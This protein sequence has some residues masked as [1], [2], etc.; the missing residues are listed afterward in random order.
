MHTSRHVF[1]GIPKVCQTFIWRLHR[2]NIIVWFHTTFRSTGFCAHGRRTWRDYSVWDRC[3]YPNRGLGAGRSTDICKDNSPIPAIFIVR[4]VTV[5]EMIDLTWDNSSCRV[6]GSEVPGMETCRTNRGI[7]YSDRMIDTRDVSDIVD[8]SLDV[9]FYLLTGWQNSQTKAMSMLTGLFA[10]FSLVNIA[11]LQRLDQGVRHN[12][13]QRGLWF[14]QFNLTLS[15]NHVP[16]P[17]V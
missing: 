13:E 10:S 12:L 5:S 16:L 8:S 15:R 1:F 17:V 4:Y 9:E 2:S 7:W 11:N 14:G 3:R 6:S